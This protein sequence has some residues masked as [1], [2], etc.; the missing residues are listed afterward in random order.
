[1]QGLLDFFAAN[2]DGLTIALQILGIV[3]GVLVAYWGAWKLIIERLWKQHVRIDIQAFEVITDATKL[4]PKLLRSENNDDPLADH[5]IEYQ[6]RDPERDTQIELKTALNKK[7]YLLVTAPSGYGKTR[8]GGMLAESL[9][10]AGYRVVQIHDDWLEIPKNLPKEL[11]GNRNKILIF[12]DDL[13]GLFRAGKDI[14]SPRAQDIPLLSQK[15]YHDRL[16]EVLGWFE[17]RCGQ[18]EIRVIATA[19]SDDWDVLDF[20][21]NDNLWKRFTRVELSEPKITSVINLLD[22]ASKSAGLK[23]NK[24]DFEAIAHKND[25]TYRNIV[26]NLQKFQAENSEVTKENYSAAQ[27]GSWREFYERICSDRPAIQYLYAAIEL[28]RQARINLYTF[29]IEPI[30]LLLWAGNPFQRLIRQREIH[31]T[32]HYLTDEIKKLPKTGDELAPHDGQI[33]VWDEPIHWQP[34]AEGLEKLLLRLSKTH[35]EKMND[36]LFGFGAAAYYEKQF[37][38][39][40]RMWEKLLEIMPNTFSVSSNLGVVLSELK[41]YDEA[42]AAYRTAIELDPP[43][44]GAYN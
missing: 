14:Q 11:E 25:G 26:L 19:R 18:D 28:A 31:N 9:M 23:A 3:G 33:E 43:D 35:T 42:E 20:D 16:V 41:R 4:L 21:Q 44:A 27:G 39:S 32:L 22:Q 24:D 1:M 7:R 36:S 40:E 5:N 15:P 13:N 2:K 12:L 29:A 37:Q 38:R 6:E 8:E 30:A 34:F 17:A 10:R